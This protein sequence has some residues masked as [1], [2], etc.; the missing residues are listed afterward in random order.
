MPSR[1]TWAAPWLRYLYLLLWGR[2]ARRVVSPRSIDEGIGVPTKE[3]PC[4]HLPGGQLILNVVRTQNIE[5]DNEEIQTES[6][7]LE[8]EVT[9]ILAVLNLGGG[10]IVVGAI[11]AVDAGVLDSP[12]PLNIHARDQVLAHGIARVHAATWS[13]ATCPSRKRLRT[14]TAPRGPQGRKRK[15]ERWITTWRLMTSG[16]SAKERLWER[17]A[18]KYWLFLKKGRRMIQ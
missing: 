11:K 1:A 8:A 12:F 6:K 3:C 14:F 5:F 10:D 9:A 4:R 7:I 13:S 15:E 18:N 17:R 2:W 16:R